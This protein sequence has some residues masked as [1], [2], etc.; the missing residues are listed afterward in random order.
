MKYLVSAIALALA[1]AATGPAF[2]GDVSKATTKA[3]CDKAGGMWN[4][5]SSTCTKKS[6]SNY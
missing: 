5:D 2:A 6:G 4:A 1:L 3:D